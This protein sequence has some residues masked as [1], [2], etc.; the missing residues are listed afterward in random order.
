MKETLK[1]LNGMV[2]DGVISQYAIGGAVA[3]IYYVEAFDTADLIIFVQIDVRESELRILAPIYDYLRKRRYKARGEFVYIEG[4][5][6]QFLPVFNEL[7]E[8]AVIEANTITFARVNTRL[9]RAEH[10]VAIMLDTGRPKDYLRIVMF[11]EQKAVDMR[12]LKA[13]LRRHG[14]I[15]KWKENEHKFKP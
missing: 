10:L 7:T 14:L 1:L 15:K 9:M 13:V 6:V 3:A 8:E 2:K 4:L 11:L 5:P 12:L